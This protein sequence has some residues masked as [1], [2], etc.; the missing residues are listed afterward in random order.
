VIIKLPVRKIN[1][2]SNKA[3]HHTFEC[4]SRVVRRLIDFSTIT[5]F[6][7]DIRKNHTEAKIAIMMPITAII[8][9]NE[10]PDTTASDWEIFMISNAKAMIPQNIAPPK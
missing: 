4:L 9:I 7:Q 10:N 2:V 5:G 1:P 6:A 3:K 8:L